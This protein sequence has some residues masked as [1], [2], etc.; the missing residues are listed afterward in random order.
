MTKINQPLFVTKGV[1]ESN[2]G[3]GFY[4]E[5]TSTSCVTSATSSHDSEKELSRI[6]GS[7]NTPLTMWFEHT[8]FLSF[9][10]W[11]PLVIEFSPQM[12][13]SLVDFINQKYNN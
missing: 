12:E 7:V 4:K 10:K 3:R 8:W 1:V 6:F 2:F 11:Q 13:K 9:P 5:Y